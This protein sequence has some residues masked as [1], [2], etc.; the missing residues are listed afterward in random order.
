MK[1]VIYQI[2]PRSFAD[3]NGDGVGDLRG[4]IGKLD[5]LKALG[6][7][8]IWLSPIFCSPMV[9]NG[10]DISDYR[11]VDPLFGNLEDL[12]E[13]IACAKERGIGV[14]LDLVLNHT[15]NAHPWFKQALSDPTSKYRDYYIFRKGTD[16][17]P[18][19]NWR[20]NFGDSAWELDAGT[21][22]YYLHV[23]AKEQPD[24]NW[25][26]PV[27][28]EELYSM[29]RWWLEKGVAGFR[30]DA[31]SFIKKDLSFVSLPPD[32]PDG[33]AD[34]QAHWVVYP[35]IEVFLAEMRNKAFAPYNAYTVAEAT[36]VPH[37]RLAEFIGENGYFSAVFDFSYTDIDLANGNWHSLRPIPKAAL[38][39]AIF[40]SQLAVSAAGHGAVYFE[41]HDQ[42]RS[43][44]K[45]L[46]PNEICY[47]SV[48]MLGALYFFLQGTAF[49][50]Q[51]QE[52]GITNYPWQSLE[53][54]NDVATVDQYQRALALGL[55]EQEALAIVSQRSRD[56]ARIPMLWDYGKNSGFS[57]GSPWLP[58]HPDYPTLCAAA[59]DGIPHT[60][61]QFYRDMSALRHGDLAKLFFD[62]SFAPAYQEQEGIFAYRRA[63]DSKTVLVVCNFQNNDASLELPPSSVLIGN[64]RSG[65]E[66]LSGRTT[67]APFEVLVL[68]EKE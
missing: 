6:V 52:L 15:S 21:G 7:D 38:R 62:G 55:S 10:Y 37:E 60:I 47:E 12:E 29:I 61:L 3:A 53:Q 54:F 27:L 4:I 43:P 68:L 5:Y 65:L 57:D 44:N 50:Y 41:N 13:L 58:V 9:D 18:P 49:I 67:L 32:A 26:N 45:Y 30:I 59:Q 39:D 28:R 14:L 36:G 17:S 51:G 40:N 66:D 22:E 63:L 64:K 23:F 42:N 56:N 8:T 11:G 16:N 25:E 2:Y 34:A 24:L 35:G 48:T 31:I 20:S 1:N 33:L 19:N 46:A